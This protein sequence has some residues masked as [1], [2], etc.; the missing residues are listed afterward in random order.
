MEYWDGL[1]D[2]VDRG[3]VRAVGVMLPVGV[4]VGFLMLAVVARPRAVV[5]MLLAGAPHSQGGG[6]GSFPLVVRRLIRRRWRLSLCAR[7]GWQRPGRCC[8]GRQRPS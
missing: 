3:L 2:A 1:A 7:L 6:L 8:L 4:T 5:R